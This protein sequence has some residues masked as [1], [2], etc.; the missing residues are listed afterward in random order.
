MPVYTVQIAYIETLTRTHTL[1]VRANT[2]EEAE[3]FARRGFLR[4]QEDGPATVQVQGKDLG[5]VLDWEALPVE[6]TVV[7]VGMLRGDKE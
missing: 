6:K 4:A 7:V 1:S 5:F 2:I 3:G